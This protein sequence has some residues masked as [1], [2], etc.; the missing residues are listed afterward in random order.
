M[1]YKLTIYKKFQVWLRIA[2]RTSR[3]M[4]DHTLIFPRENQS[5]F[6]AHSYWTSSPYLVS[7]PDADEV[8]YIMIMFPNFQ[9]R[10]NHLW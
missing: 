4:A 8:E 7:N 2:V 6:K 1:I 3:T 9:A 5:C 10:A